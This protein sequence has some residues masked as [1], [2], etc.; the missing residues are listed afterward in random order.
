MRPRLLRGLAVAAV[1]VLFGCASESESHVVFIKSEETRHRTD[2]WQAS[3]LPGGTL[4]SECRLGDAL[5]AGSEGSWGLTIRDGSLFA[6]AP[7]GTIECA[8]YLG[9]ETSG[10]FPLQPLAAAGVTLREPVACLYQR[11]PI[12]LVCATSDPQLYVGVARG[13]PDHFVSLHRANSRAAM[14]RAAAR[15]ASTYFQ[16][17]G[18]DDVF[19]ALDTALAKDDDA[20]I[21]ATSYMIGLGASREP[22]GRW[23]SKAA[24]TKAA[25][26]RAIAERPQRA[27]AALDGLAAKRAADWPQ[28][29]GLARWVRLRDD[30]WDGERLARTAGVQSLGW[31]SQLEAE[32]E[33]LFRAETAKANDPPRTLG[34]ACWLWIRSTP[35]L[36]RGTHE[37]MA[38]A[39]VKLLRCDDFLEARRHFDYVTSTGIRDGDDYVKPC[40]QIGG[41]SRILAIDPLA[42]AARREAARCAAAGK[43]AMALWWRAGV[44][45]WLLDTARGDLYEK[46]AAPNFYPRLEEIEATAKALAG[47]DAAMAGDGSPFARVGM[48]ASAAA[49]VARIEDKQPFANHYLRRAGSQ[50]LRAGYRLEAAPLAQLA[51]AYAA[52]GFGAAAAWTQLCAVVAAGSLPDAPYHD[53]VAM[54]DKQQ[55][56]PADVRRFL[57]LA[58][59][60]VA[61]LG[62]PIA[63]ATSNR[64]RMVEMQ[65]DGVVVRGLPALGF[66][67]DPLTVRERLGMTKTYLAIQQ[68]PD[69]TALVAEQPTPPTAAEQWGEVVVDPPMSA[70]L[71]AE[72]AASKAE[73]D[74]LDVQWR[75]AGGNSPRVAAELQQQEA[76]LKAEAEQLAAR[77]ASMRDEDYRAAERDLQRRVDMFG[78]TARQA[79]ARGN[80]NRQKLDELLANSREALARKAALEVRI[81]QSKAQWLARFDA[82][83]RP[84]HEK[85]LQDKLAAWQEV[86]SRALPGGDDLQFDL[87]CGAF[88]AGLGDFPKAMPG[89][90]TQA[91]VMLE[92]VGLRARLRRTEDPAQMLDVFAKVLEV[93]AAGPLD[94]KLWPVF[95]NDAVSDAYAR[96]M[97]EDLR[98]QVSVRFPALGLDA[99]LRDLLAYMAN[100]KTL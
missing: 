72:S 60:L 47:L 73:L 39:V 22:G 61:E 80:E 43:P 46:H 86:R 21:T 1:L 85:L 50:A 18:A 33:A 27:R 25:V 45:Q 5:P 91:A 92:L 96:G 35:K 49:A 64:D 41:Y 10:G 71:A 12:A 42:Q 55:E 53:F 84:A 65:H 30:V 79:A 4:F 94:A 69:G 97:I 2:E 29:D 90:R 44:A 82:A 95:R 38:A 76:A 48:Y 16:T 13:F 67:T 26:E 63:A 24:A 52:K 19:A 3:F 9:R 99:P 83:V 6:S 78:V 15:S 75:T 23:A 98:R 68:G 32:A 89:L 28:L 56:L 34:E 93:G 87:V 88:F 7:D 20:A 81:A 17:K 51:E 8:T 57:E 58:A 59:P 62:A 70:E 36:P 74:A 77:R 40:I 66:V 100:Y 37:G 54:F 31:P 11:E 14:L